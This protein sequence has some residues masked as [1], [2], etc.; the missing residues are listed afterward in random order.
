MTLQLERRAT[1]ID[2]RAKARK[3]VGYASV[4]DTP[5]QIM[6]F[7]ETVA[8]GA[9]ADSLKDRAADQVALLDHDLGKLLGR[10][11]SG[12]LR[13]AEDDHG[14]HFEIDVPDT[15]LGRDVLALAERGDL[16][17]ASF[18]FITKRD[19][20]AGTRRTLNAVDLREISVVSAWPAYSASSVTAR[21]AGGARSPLLRRITLLELGAR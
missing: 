15:T 5:T 2:L 20:W 1:A 11:R 16:G 7:T 21:S 12:T 14:L 19:T 6:D 4:F 17:G 13:L 10:S 18:G 8:R 9:F 3:L